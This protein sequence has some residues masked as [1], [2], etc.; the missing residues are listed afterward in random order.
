MN[1]DYLGCF[2]AIQILYAQTKLCFV[3]AAPAL[4]LRVAFI[5]S[6]VPMNAVNERS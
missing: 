2:K 5:D 6:I 3:S 4:I 1:L